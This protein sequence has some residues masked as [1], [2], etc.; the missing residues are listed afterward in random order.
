MNLW[1]FSWMKSVEGSIALN[2][3]TCLA[4][5]RA[6]SELHKLWSRRVVESEKHAERLDD[7]TERAV[8]TDSTLRLLD[9]DVDEIQHQLDS[10]DSK[11]QSLKAFTDGLDAR[12]NHLEKIL[13]A[14]DDEQVDMWDA[15]K[16][17]Q[18]KLDQANE[19][20]INLSLALASHSNRICDLEDRLAKQSKKGKK[21]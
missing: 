19:R 14:T 9:I 6:L 21:A 18:D 8:E 11:I 1:P 2:T 12:C 16:S 3:D 10:G 4:H 20:C 5:E 15:I 7:L 13:H 17:L